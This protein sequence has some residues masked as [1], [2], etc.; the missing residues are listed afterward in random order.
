MRILFYFCFVIAAIKNMTL[1]E[2]QFSNT[3]LEIIL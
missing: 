3:F 1:D 2:T